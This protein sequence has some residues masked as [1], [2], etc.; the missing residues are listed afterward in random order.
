MAVTEAV[1]WLQ[2]D[3][4]AP[5]LD[6][7]IFCAFD[8]P[9]AIRYPAVDGRESVSLRAKPKV[10]KGKCSVTNLGTYLGTAVVIMHPLVLPVVHRI[11]HQYAVSASSSTTFRRLK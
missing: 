10:T 7:L 9:N 5:T 6:R 3:E 2:K 11:Y 8:D 1:Q 4:H